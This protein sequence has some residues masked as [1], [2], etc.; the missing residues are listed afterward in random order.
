MTLLLLIL[1][2]FVLAVDKP[3]LQTCCLSLSSL[4]NKALYILNYDTTAHA[5]RLT[6]Q[7]LKQTQLYNM[8]LHKI[9]KV[10]AQFCYV[11]TSICYKQNMTFWSHFAIDVIENRSKI[12]SL[13]AS[14]TITA[15]KTTTR[16]ARERHIHIINNGTVH[17]GN[18]KEAYMLMHR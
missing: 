10:L 7:T 13:P 6:D 1:P 9:C 4:I 5:A 11:C 16:R 18:T 8:F 15:G 2:S 17:F 12:I 14:S 3:N